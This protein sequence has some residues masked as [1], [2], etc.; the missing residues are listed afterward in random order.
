MI[1]VPAKCLCCGAEYQGGHQLPEKPMKEGLRVFYQCGA[2][3]S[4]K[5]LFEGVY[6]ILFKNCCKESPGLLSLHK[7][8]E[9]R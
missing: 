9:G 3:M 7:G 4:V 5:V 8:Q 6:Q 1:K 2:S